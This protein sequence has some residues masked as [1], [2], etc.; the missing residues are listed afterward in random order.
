MAELL[1]SR[2]SLVVHYFFACQVARGNGIGPWKTPRR[3][4]R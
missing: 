3:I 4:E 1:T 2:V